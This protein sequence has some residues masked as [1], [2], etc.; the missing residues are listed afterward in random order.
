MD[1]VSLY[2]FSYIFICETLNFK[3]KKIY[4]KQTNKAF[5]LPIFKNEMK[6]KFEKKK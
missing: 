3:K 5:S 1:S 4:F 6:K 2:L